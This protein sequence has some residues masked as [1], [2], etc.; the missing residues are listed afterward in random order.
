MIIKE[1]TSWQRIMKAQ[2]MQTMQTMQVTATLRIVIVQTAALTW[3][4]IALRTNHPTKRL[5]KHLTSLPI[6]QTI[7]EIPTKNYL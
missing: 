1:A 3:A 2:A 6:R 4:Q 7:A 5:T